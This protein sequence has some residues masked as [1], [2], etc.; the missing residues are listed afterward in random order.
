MVKKFSKNI[1]LNYS[2]LDC[3]LALKPS[4]LF[5]ELQD[6]ASQ[7]ADDLGFGFSFVKENN[8]AWYLLKYHME[9]NSYP[10]NIEKMTLETLSRGYSRMFAFRDF[11]L[12]NNENLLGKMTSTWALINKSTGEIFP[13]K[14]VPQNDNFTPFEKQTDDMSYNKIPLIENV[15]REKTFEVRFEDIDVNKHA[16]NC[17]YIIWAL[18]T[19]TFEERTRKIKTL[20]V[21]YKKEITYGETVVSQV[22][23]KEN[24]T[25]H[26]LKNAKTDDVLCSI[27]VEWE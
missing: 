17:N 4:M 15:M 6:I 12:Y 3:N 18:E 11:W 10:K 9:F 2:E 27:L 25:N 20:D 14:N 22:E 19:L 5:Q 21:N 13:F 8:L 26:V 23:I 7:N 1:N 24:Q 16:N